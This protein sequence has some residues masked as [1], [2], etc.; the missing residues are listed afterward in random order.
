MGI[1]ERPLNNMRRI[2]GGIW[3]LFCGGEYMKLSKNERKYNK[4][5]TVCIFT[6]SPVK[7]YWC[8]YHKIW[9][10]PNSQRKIYDVKQPGQSSLHDIQMCRGKVLL[11]SH[12][13]DAIKA[14]PSWPSHANNLSVCH[15]C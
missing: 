8:D 11:L 15:S 9:C 3:V 1:T 12:L 4:N 7:Y 2:Y 13:S 14:V 6:S 5:N 10:P